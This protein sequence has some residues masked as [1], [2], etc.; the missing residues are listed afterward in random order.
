[1]TNVCPKQHK[2]HKIEKSI[3]VKNKNKW[4]IVKNFAF[5]SLKNRNVKYNYNI[6]I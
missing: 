1:M 2:L 5:L 4:F 6:Y 3:F